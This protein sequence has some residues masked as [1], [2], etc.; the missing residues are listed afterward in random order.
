MNAV[1][2]RFT[3]RKDK[4]TG[5]TVYYTTHPT[6]VKIAVIPKSD[7]NSAYAVFGTRYGSID[8]C[9]GVNG[10]ALVHVP[11]GIAH[12][13]EHK[14]FESEEC[15]AFER[16]AATG[17]CVN[18]YTSSDKTCYFFSCSAE[19]FA[20]SFE[21]L[22]DFVQ[23]PYFTPETVEKE[24]GIIEQEIKMYEDSPYTRVHNN[25]MQAMYPQHPVHIDIGGTVESIREITAEL[26]Y[27]CYDTFYHP[28]NMVIAVAGNVNPMC[29][30]EIC[31]R[32]LQSKEPLQIERDY[33][34]DGGR[35]EQH[36]IEQQFD[37]PV[38]LFQLGFKEQ[39]RRLTD[40]E[41]VLFDIITDAVFGSMSDFYTEMVEKELLNLTLGSDYVYMEGVL[42]TILAGYSVAPEGLRD[43]IFAEIRRVKAEGISPELFECA[44]RKLYA[45]MIE[46]F[47]N[48]DDIGDFLADD[49]LFD[50]DFLAQL[51]AITEVTVEEGSA[52]FREIFDI[53]N[54]TLSVV[55]NRKEIA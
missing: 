32:L 1:S 46:I 41:F 6:G 51:Q 19:S 54:S 29:V 16:F 12:Y 21:I 10:G 25:L 4:L 28:G 55:R 49:L 35:V 43:E 38:P 50:T 47:N 24:R 14:L 30:L 42:T 18:A 39:Y 31:D 26:L 9:F 36:F 22:L 8:N 37:V 5:E 20:P 45:A 13:L 33:P 11:D 17:A 52:F 3:V 34:E 53:D 7:Y 27:E 2:D 23:T 40:R 15:G 44:R 48:V